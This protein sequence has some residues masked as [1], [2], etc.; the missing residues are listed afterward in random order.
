[1][2]SSPLDQGIEQFNQQD[3]YARHDTLEAIWM[4]APEGERNF[5]QGILQ[6]AVACYHLSNHN[7][8][9][10]VTLLGE[11][12]RRLRSYQPNYEGVNVSQLLEDS[13][14]LLYQVQQMT[15][16]VIPQ[17]VKTTP[18]PKIYPVQEPSP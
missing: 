2:S 1:M 7:W 10:T 4:E 17:W 9:G 6:I 12:T 15:P 14:D 8:R 18:Y 11:G 5:Y 16:E 13:L 3:F